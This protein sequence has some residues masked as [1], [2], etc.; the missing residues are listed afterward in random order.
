MHMNTISAGRRVHLECV[1]NVGISHVIGINSILREKRRNNKKILHFK[2]GLTL[3]HHPFNQ[4]LAI[5][6]I[7]KAISTVFLCHKQGHNSTRVG[8]R[9][10]RAPLAL[11]VRASY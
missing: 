3:L 6:P 5:L 10:L 4:R 9:L 11:I 8:D 1:G 2:Q 7:T